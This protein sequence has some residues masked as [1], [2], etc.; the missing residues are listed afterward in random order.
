MTPFFLF[1]AGFYVSL[2][3][4]HCFFHALID[5]GVGR[6]K[7]LTSFRTGLRPSKNIVSNYESLS[8][9]FCFA[10]LS[11]GRLQMFRR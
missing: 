8:A 6:E 3:A 5:Q 10:V 1:V 9:E 11:H 7:F 4:F 2:T